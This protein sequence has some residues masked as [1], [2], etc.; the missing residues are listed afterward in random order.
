MTWASDMK[1]L[2][3]RCWVLRCTVWYWW[4]ER[5]PWFIALRLPRKV[6][7]LAFVRVYGVLGECGPDYDRVYTEWERRGSVMNAGPAK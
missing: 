7:L 3:F 6:A 4:T 1:W 2:A 5:L